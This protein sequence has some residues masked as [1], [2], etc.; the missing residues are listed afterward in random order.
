MRRCLGLLAVLIPLAAGCDRFSRREPPRPVVQRHEP[1]QVQLPPTADRWVPRATLVRGATPERAVLLVHQLAS[2]RSEWAP[3]V[4]RLREAPAITTLAI[5]LRGHGE[6]TRGPMGNAVSWTS[7]GTD[8]AQ[9]AGVVSDVTSAAGY[10][11]QL[12]A[13]R[14]VLVG[15][16]IGAS[17]CAQVAASRAEVEGLVMISPGLSYQ[18][19]DARQPFGAFIAGGHPPHRALL[20]GAAGDPPAAEALPVLARLGVGRVESTLFPNERRHGVSLCNTRSE[21]WDRIESFIRQTLD[22]PRAAS[23]RNDAGR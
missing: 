1:E 9:W 13:T 21:R 4:H 18:G 5:D 17:A 20:L 6:S 8:A 16:S 3:L 22:A 10:L 2:D 15:S 19:L 23:A 12:Q 7:F 14:V 11:A